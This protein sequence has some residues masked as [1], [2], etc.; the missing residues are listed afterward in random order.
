MD[1]NRIFNKQRNQNIWGSSS[2]AARNHSS[3]TSVLHGIL[4]KPYSKKMRKWL[5]DLEIMDTQAGTAV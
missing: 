5:Q 3:M 4:F 1:I 2:W